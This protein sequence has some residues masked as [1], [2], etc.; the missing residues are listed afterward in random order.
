MPRRPGRTDGYALA[1]A[2]VPDCRPVAG[3]SG[4]SDAERA[5]FS[6]LPPSRA[7]RFL[8]GRML[9]REL[10]AQ[11][12]DVPTGSVR[13]SA[14]CPDCR[15]EHGRPVVIAPARATG[16]RV[17]LSHAG[18]LVLAAVA[19]R[20]AV[21]VDAEPWDTAPE[22]L[23]AIRALT[24]V[25]AQVSGED[26]LLSALRHWTRVE[27]VLKA[28]GRGL[29]VDP[30]AVQVLDS[31]GRAEASVVADPRRYAVT[32]PWTPHP[33]QVSVALEL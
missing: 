28:D 30:A 21:G 14:R 3:M 15:E 4:L 7:I 2:E 22:R 32:E 18:G 23:D 33:L 27:A 10:V 31:T 12:A 13:F 25:P 5:R 26:G 8:A 29:R 17:S 1:W 11:E 16:F 20:R 19:P 24:D 6:R 9:L